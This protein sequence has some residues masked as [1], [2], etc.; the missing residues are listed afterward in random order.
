MNFKDHQEIQRTAKSLCELLES[1]E[2]YPESNPDDE[3][4]ESDAD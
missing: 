1:P 4:P 3:Q 2:E